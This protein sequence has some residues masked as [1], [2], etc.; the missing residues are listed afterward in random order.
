[1]VR[2]PVALL[3]RHCSPKPSISAATFFD[4]LWQVLIHLSPSPLAIFMLVTLLRR[5]RSALPTLRRTTTS[6]KNSMLVLAARLAGSRPT[7][8][9]L[10]FLHPERLITRALP[11]ALILRAR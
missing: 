8:A 2:E 5:K 7:A 1:M 11:S 9:H 4:W 3:I 6:P 10:V